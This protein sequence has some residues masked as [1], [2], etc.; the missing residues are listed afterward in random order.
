MVFKDCK[1]YSRSYDVC[2]RIGKPFK[3]D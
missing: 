1:E 3:R 2:Q